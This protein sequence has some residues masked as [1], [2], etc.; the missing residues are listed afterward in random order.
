MSH[1]MTFC[2]ISRECSSRAAEFKR[3]FVDRFTQTTS[4]YSINKWTNNSVVKLANVTYASIKRVVNDGSTFAIALLKFLLLLIFSRSWKKN[5]S[6]SEWQKV[7]SVHESFILLECQIC[8]PTWHPEIR[9]T[10]RFLEPWHC[11]RW[12]GINI[13]KLKTK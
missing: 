11:K 8:A 9:L 12:K 13:C 1:F 3:M 4:Y 2:N 10:H 7:T 6:S 5:F